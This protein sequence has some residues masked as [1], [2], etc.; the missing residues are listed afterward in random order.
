M[1]RL[2]HQLSFSYDSL[3]GDPF[4]MFKDVTFV[5]IRALGPWQG[6]SYG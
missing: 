6:P 3:T 4:E 2:S 1:R 5:I